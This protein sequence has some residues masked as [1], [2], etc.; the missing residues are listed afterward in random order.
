MI[1]KSFYLLALLVATTASWA[2]TMGLEN[3]LFPLAKHV[4][5]ISTFLIIINFT[6]FHH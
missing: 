3:Q 1:K 5:P 4:Q 2:Q 6:A